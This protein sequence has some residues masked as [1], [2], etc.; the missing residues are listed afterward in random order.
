[1]I[2]LNKKTNS[3]FTLIETL[4]YLAIFIL[5]SA[6]IID[7]LFAIQKTNRNVAVLSGLSTN[8]VSVFERITKETREAISVNVASST[9]ATSS[10]VLQLN[11]V[12][13]S[14]VPHVTK[15]YQNSG[16]VKMDIDGLYFGPLMTNSATSTALIFNI[17]T[18]STSTLIKMELD[19][20]AGT[21]TYQ[22][23]EKFYDSITLRL[24]N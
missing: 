3:G 7:L 17:A 18:T 12:D 6:G 14:D 16:Q 19:L 5:I 15:F 11:T 8:A 24:N 22:K 13:V 10:G 2:K 1:M 21:S 9:F 4:I 23:A 20:M